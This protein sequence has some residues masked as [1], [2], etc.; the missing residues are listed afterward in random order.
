MKKQIITIA[1]V[2]SLLAL[3]GCG[4]DAGSTADPSS[5]SAKTTAASEETTNTTSSKESA[6]VDKTTTESSSKET[7]ETAQLGKAIFGGYVTADTAVK[8]KPDANSDT[9]VTIISDTQ[10]N[11]HESGVDGWFMTDF[12]GKI[13]YIPANVVKEIQ[14]FDPILGSDNVHNGTASANTKLMSG[15][16]R[17]AELI[18]VIPSGAQLVYYADPSDSKWCIVNYQD[19]VGYAEAKDIKETEV[20]VT[21]SKEEALKN[22]IGQWKSTEQWNGNDLYINISKNDG[23]MKAEVSTHSAVADYQWEYTCIGSDDG[24]FIECTGG[25]TKKRTDHSP[26]GDTQET[27]T[28]YSDGTARFNI[29]GGTLF[30]ED[31]KEGTASQVGFSKSE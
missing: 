17:Y 24:T 21:E 5:G 29:K 19:K 16:H 30:W 12:Q 15:T 28:E 8:S 9:L 23:S 18:A 3:T 31:S 11:V 1:V 2:S 27:V 26:N 20:N 25:G 4:S 13:G 22:Y 14:P 10:I 7:E 6:K